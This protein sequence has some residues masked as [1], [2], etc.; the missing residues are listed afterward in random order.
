MGSVKNAADKF[1][2]TYR[3][4]NL[5][6]ILPHSIA[7]VVW[8]EKEEE[9]DF[10]WYGECPAGRFIFT[11]LYGKKKVFTTECDT[12]LFLYSIYNLLHQVQIV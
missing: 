12:I 4:A 8:T 3:K 11:G 2:R 1:I 9:L 7:V 5:I 10:Q 6:N